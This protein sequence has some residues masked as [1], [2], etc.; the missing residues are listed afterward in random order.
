MNK[1]IGWKNELDEWINLTIWINKRVDKGWM[2][3][4]MHW[5]VDEINELDKLNK[6]VNV[7]NVR[8]RWMYELVEF[9]ELNE[10][11]EWFRW[12]W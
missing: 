3:Q 2:K 8:I 6:W 12:I 5:R 4:G 7:I 11:G 10:L 9:D 1:W